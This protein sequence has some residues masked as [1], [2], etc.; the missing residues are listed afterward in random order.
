[1]I[2]IK[3]YYHLH[4]AYLDKAILEDND[5]EVFVANENSHTIKPDGFTPNVFLQ[6]NENDVEKALTILKENENWEDE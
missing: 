6:V 5:I 4:E 1:M 2:K 3:E